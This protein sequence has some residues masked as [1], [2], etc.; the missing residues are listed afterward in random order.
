VADYSTAAF[1]S[2]AFYRHEK[3]KTLVEKQ[4]NPV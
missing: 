3:E 1:V 4:G 2:E